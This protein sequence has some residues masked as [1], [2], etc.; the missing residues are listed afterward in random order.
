MFVSW[1]RL[2]PSTQEIHGVRTCW[3]STLAVVVVSNLLEVG[4]VV[5]GKIARKAQR[6]WRCVCCYLDLFSMN[7]LYKQAHSGMLV[8]VLVQTLPFALIYEL[9]MIVGS[10]LECSFATQRNL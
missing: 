10:Y 1:S 6:L 4:T 2:V 3:K 8:E 7:Q 9:S 5:R